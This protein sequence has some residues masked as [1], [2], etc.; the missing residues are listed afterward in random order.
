[1]FLDLETPKTPLIAGLKAIDWL[2][3]FTI[4]GGT[5][6][7][8]FGLL[9]GGVT[10]PWSS[11]VVIALIVCGFLTI[12]LFAIIEIKLPVSPIM[13]MR[14]FGHQSNVAALGVC[15]FHGA[16]FISA[17]YFLPLYFQVVHSASPT[18]SGYLLLPS[19][20]SISTF[21]VLAGLIIK[22]TGKY[23]PTLLISACLMAIGTGLFIDF[24]NEANT[25]LYKIVIYQI[26]WGIG[27][28]PNFQAPLIALQT[29]ISQA[30][31]ATATA[32]YGFVRSIATAISVVLGSVVFNNEMENR[33]GALVDA[34]GPEAARGLSGENAG[35]S[36]DV[37]AEL[38]AAEQAVVKQAFADSLRTMWIMYVVLACAAVVV[39]LFVRGQVLSEEHVET[40]TG[41]DAL[42]ADGHG[43]Q[44]EQGGNGGQGEHGR[45]EGTE[46]NGTSCH[47]K[48]RGARWFGTARFPT[49]KKQG[50]E[51]VVVEMFHREKAEA[52][53]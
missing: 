53:Q 48:N 30:D 41:L 23:V 1:M 14:I 11:P 21:A 46:Q 40:K 27:V 18:R 24:D 36:V 10:R 44:D 33:S 6:M 42:Q 12:I 31:I 4:V 35:A 39:G 45:N 19:A 22:K 3:A 13:P 15:F 37:V 43:G 50:N 5:L 51:Q 20:V 7:L 52:N 29:L 17:S 9:L 2:G 26:I 16:I 38:P 28:G 25:P 8:L 34:L 32:T 47:L 49:T